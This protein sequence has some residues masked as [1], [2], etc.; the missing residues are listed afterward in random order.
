MI[1]H[2]KWSLTELEDMMPFERE[3]YATLLVNHLKEEEERQK[4]QQLDARN[5]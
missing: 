5:R 3:I 4:Q 2:H 1:Q